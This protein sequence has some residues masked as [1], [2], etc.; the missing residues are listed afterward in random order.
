MKTWLSAPPCGN[1]RLCEAS[2]PNTP[3]TYDILNQH[4]GVTHRHSGAGHT[5][6][7]RLLDYTEEEFGPFIDLCERMFR[8][9]EDRERRWPAAA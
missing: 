7:G 2:L 5:R 9:W 4:E 1:P 8:K 3:P 6:M